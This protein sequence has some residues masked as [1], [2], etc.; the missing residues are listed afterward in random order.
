MA[1]H[2]ILALVITIMLLVASIA[3]SEKQN[4]KCKENPNSSDSAM[5]GSS[6]YQR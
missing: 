5:I 4:K 6:K 1:C 2:A 3:S